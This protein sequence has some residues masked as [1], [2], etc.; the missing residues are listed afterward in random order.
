MFESGHT[1][2]QCLH[3]WWLSPNIQR[4]NISEALNL[5]EGSDVQMKEREEEG[6]KAQ[7]KQVQVQTNAWQSRWKGK[8]RNR[9]RK[10]RE[11]ERAQSGQSGCVRRQARHVYARRRDKQFRPRAWAWTCRVVS[12]RM[13]SA[14][15]GQIPVSRYFG[16]LPVL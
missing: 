10:G 16:A 7:A 12:C 5:Y 8:A 13:Q 15:A 4:A 11:E 2:T 14:V 3:R 1:C 9:K 6:D